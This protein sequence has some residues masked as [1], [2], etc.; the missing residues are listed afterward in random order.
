[1]DFKQVL[2]LK[3]IKRCEARSKHKNT[4]IEKPMVG[5]R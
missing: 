4:N 1:M 5:W 2:L 3:T